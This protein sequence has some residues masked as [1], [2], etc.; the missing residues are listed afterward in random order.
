MRSDIDSFKENAYNFNRILYET[1]C[2]KK[3]Q[4]YM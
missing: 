3:K 4:R 1:D 2:K